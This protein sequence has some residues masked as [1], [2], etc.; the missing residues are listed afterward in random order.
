MRNLS[1]PVSIKLKACLFLF[2]GLLSGVLLLVDHLT[3]K[4]GLLLTLTI[5]CFCRFYYFTF[6]VIEYYVDPNYRFS[7][8]VSFQLHPARLGRRSMG[9]TFRK[10]RFT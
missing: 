6:Y 4:S 8:L 10:M 2:L 7:G 1:N 9:I 5:W 3:L